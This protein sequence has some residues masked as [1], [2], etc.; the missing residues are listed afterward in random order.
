MIVCDTGPLVV[1]AD[2]D[3]ADNRA[4]TDLLT[5][6]HLAGR[7][8][9]VPAPVVA[10]VG[11][12]LGRASGAAVEAAFLR[13]IA[14]RSLTIVDL[15]IDDYTRMAELVE[16]YADFPLGTTDA[17]VVAVSERLGITEVATLDRRHFHAVRPRH[18]AAL[19][20]LP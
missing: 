3:D 9:L 14:E 10:E 19:T 16:T 18:T 12:L 13:S 5:S 6:L 17:A 20:L 2:R 7:A 8:I 15:Q 1:A 4:C 11:H